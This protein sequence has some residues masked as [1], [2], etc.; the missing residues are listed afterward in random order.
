MQRIGTAAAASD[1]G[2]RADAEG[3][4]WEGVRRARHADD[5]LGDTRTNQ[6]HEAKMSW[7]V[8]VCRGVEVGSRVPENQRTRKLK[9]SALA[10]CGM[11]KVR[12]E[13]SVQRYD[14]VDKTESQCLLMR[15]K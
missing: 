4:V 1:S 13:D 11:I 14:P 9:R 3:D 7:I 2:A 12:R 15:K 8:D 6:R 5:T 10:R